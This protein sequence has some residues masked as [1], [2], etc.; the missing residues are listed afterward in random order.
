MHGWT[1]GVLQ[2]E[3]ATLDGVED[4]VPGFEVRVDAP[5]AQELDHAVH[6][7]VLRVAVEEARLRDVAARWVQ[8]EAADVDDAE[9]TAVVGLV[10][11]T[12][13]DLDDERCRVSFAPGREERMREGWY[14]PAFAKRK[15]LHI[16]YGR[17]TWLGIGNSL[18]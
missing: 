12:V 14:F 5:G 10:G 16:G 15:Y 3:D 1:A 17:S 18:C 2:C 11:E 13:D 8:L 7:V 6:V 4:D 9:T